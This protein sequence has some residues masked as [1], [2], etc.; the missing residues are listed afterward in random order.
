[1]SGA[2]GIL[3]V[4]VVEFLAIEHEHDVA[5]LLDASRIREDRRG[6]DRGF[7]CSVARESCESAD[8]GTGEFA[9]QV[10]EAA[11]NV[12]HCWVRFSPAPPVGDFR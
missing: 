10:L 12:A 1:M 5:I 3:A 7:L 8:D 2:V 6:W 11:G 4:L 9:G